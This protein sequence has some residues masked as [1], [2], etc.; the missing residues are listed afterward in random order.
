VAI[1]AMLA[2][3]PVNGSISWAAFN[4]AFSP[5]G[6]V[7]SPGFA[8]PANNTDK[9]FVWWRYN[10]G[11][12][13]IETGDYLPDGLTGSKAPNS[14]FDQ[15]D[16][17][18][19]TMAAGWKRGGWSADVGTGTALLSTAAG[20]RAME[21]F[22]D[23]GPGVS[24]QTDDAIDVTPGQ[25]LYL[26][27]DV[28]ASVAV[29]A[30][31]Y[32]RITRDDTKA[33]IAGTVE[34]VGA[35]TT[36]ARKSGTVVVPAGVT[37]IRPYAL[38]YAVG[39]A[40]AAA[41][42]YVK[43][44]TVSFAP[45]PAGLTPDDLLLF[46]NKQGTPVNAQNARVIDGSMIVN[47][48]ILAD[49]IGANQITGT[50]IRAGSVEA[51]HVKT[52]SLTTNVL[53][54][55]SFDN[56]IADPTF[57]TPLEAGN[58]WPAQAGYSKIPDASDVSVPPRP[59]LRVVPNGTDRIM[60]NDGAYAYAVDTVDSA[61]PTK[62]NASYF[63][64]LIAK[65]SLANS[66]G[67]III[68]ARWEL[69]DDSIILDYVGDDQA[70]GAGV[71]TRYSGTLTAPRNARKVQFFI[72]VRAIMNGG[73]V[74]FAYAGANRAGTGEL[75]VDGSIGADHI[76]ANSIHAEH[77]HA[78]V[79]TAGFV[80]AGTI[81]VGDPT[82]P[83]NPVLNPIM[84]SGHDGIRLPQPDGG[85]IHLPTDGTSARITADL[86]ATS[87]SVKDDLTISGIGQITGSVALANGITR[88][89]TLP[90]VSQEW[91]VSWLDALNG[92][93]DTSTDYWNVY[94]GLTDH[95]SNS[96]YA[97][98]AVNYFGAQIRVLN[99][100]DPAGPAA[101]YPD[102]TNG[103]SWTANFYPIGGI[104]RIG[105]D[106][107]ILGTDTNRSG[108]Y[109]YRI[110]GSSWDK[111]AELKVG[112]LNVFPKTPRLFTN[113]TNVGLVWVSNSGIITFRYYTPSLSGQTG[114]DT[115]GGGVGGVRRDIGG[116]VY[117]NIGT[118]TNGLIV[119]CRDYSVAI[120]YNTDLSRNNAIDFPRAGGAQVAG[121]MYD[122]TQGRMISIDEYGRKW[123]YSKV[124]TGTPSI[125]AAYTWYDGDT[126]VYPAGT[127]I[128]GVDKSGQVSGVHETYAS[129]VRTFAMDR[130]AW[131]VFETPPAPDE[132]VM[133]AERVDKADRIGLYIS[134]G[135]T[136]YRQAY[137]AK[138][139]RTLRGVDVFPTTG[140]VPQ[141]DGFGTAS[142]APGKITSA[143]LRADGRPQTFIDGS[144]AAN[145]DGL[146]PPGSMMFWPVATPPL[147]WLLCDGSAV[148]RA[149]YPDLYNRIGTL[150]GAGDGS[151]TFNLPDSRDRVIM[152]FGT[153]RPIRATEGL[154][155]TA[156]S[157]SHTHT[158]P[159]HTHPH[160]L[161]TASVSLNQSLTAQTGG[162]AARLTTPDAHSHAITGG[163]L[164]TG[165]DG[166]SGGNGITGANAIPH[167]ALAM[168][169]K[170]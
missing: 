114:T 24:V 37:K 3:S 48:S 123:T 21:L 125:Q 168:I 119:V 149:T 110:S 28:K 59:L 92:A 160:N 100:D 131:P 56:L 137:L 105:T 134:N 96:A 87:L 113:G 62:A 124:T 121:M 75:I 25:T 106:Y 47:E 141:A 132:K 115:S 5:T 140:P 82:D 11:S 61:D 70:G 76:Q 112:D 39:M 93:H 157:L 95:H 44:F 40:N 68:G 79:F 102:P 163:I 81:Q 10:G 85:E 22:P 88:P 6:A 69:A 20:G 145:V 126:S 159:A 117:G 111:T 50:K 166:V 108:T 146:I 155:S 86:I 60:V 89:T 18:D 98:T 1:P 84:I 170:V 133:L 143:A 91:P 2:N 90:T 78:D 122:A 34:G 65:S 26:A 45:L 152:G 94:S 165:S 127:T 63:C 77:M 23:T 116:V 135:G 97:V 57:L 51:T 15:A 151:T 12:P 41:K 150:F 33:E 17:V 53:A 64:S 164:G 104:A 148:S 30:G 156:R 42:I 138:G 154:A 153:N 27:A 167:L 29:T 7:G 16:P 118:G 158:T 66:A 49:S 136:L 19:T 80:L 52:G 83:V 130:R 71:W 38:A 55:G 120:G 9:R 103:K 129:P 67:G 46:L 8:V 4:I 43:N 31:V 107:Y 74:D 101:I 109:I 161:G 128:N 162:T 54:I 139:V 32:L 36:W 169:I 147:G 58:V 73:T 144:G 35:T 72:G 13:L 14:S 142:A 99:K